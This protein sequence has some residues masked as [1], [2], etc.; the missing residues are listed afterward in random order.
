M[1]GLVS[2]GDVDRRLAQYETA[3][4]P[5]EAVADG[6]ELG[7]PAALALVG[8]DPRERPGGRRWN[9]AGCGI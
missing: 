9:T 1:V 7:D 5:G 6:T 8:G 4:V 3:S 2:H